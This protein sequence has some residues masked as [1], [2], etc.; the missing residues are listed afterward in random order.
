MI[1][2]KDINVTPHAPLCIIMSCVKKGISMDFG[3]TIKR[4]FLIEIKTLI[5]LQEDSNGYK[6]YG[7]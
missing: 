1:E 7:L 6:G 3:K 4:L 5:Y 2:S